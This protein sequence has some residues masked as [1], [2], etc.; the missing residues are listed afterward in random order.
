M[1]TPSNTYFLGPTRVHIRNDISIGSAVSARL[2]LAI[3]TDRSTEHATQSVAM[4]RIY[5]RSTTTWLNN[6]YER[7]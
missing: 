2:G 1:C 4:D 7:A 5:V 3:M 6:K